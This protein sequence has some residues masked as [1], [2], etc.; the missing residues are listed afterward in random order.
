[1]SQHVAIYEMITDSIVRLGP[2]PF[3]DGPEKEFKFTPPSNTAT[4]NAAVL[5]FMVN[6]D[7]TNMKFRI[8]LN[9]TVIVALN[10]DGKK[11]FFVQECVGGGGNNL[12]KPG[13]TNTLKC[14]IESG[15][16]TISFSDMVIWYQRNI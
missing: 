14:L 10:E 12:L 9:G 7:S 4:D 5:S 8:S 11:R 16:G 3:N 6:T 1:M 15:G 2:L 13:V